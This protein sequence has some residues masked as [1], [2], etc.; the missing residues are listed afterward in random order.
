[1][2][3]LGVFPIEFFF[4]FS[5]RIIKTTM[6]TVQLENLRIIE[7]LQLLITVS[8]CLRGSCHSAPLSH[9]VMFLFPLHPHHH[10]HLPSIVA[11]MKLLEFIA[12]RADAVQAALY[13]SLEVPVPDGSAYCLLITCGGLCD[14]SHIC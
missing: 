2:G 11:V 9:F 8:F 10:Y 4:K 1:M 12:P 3:V 13:L 7:N 5:E 6:V 14:A